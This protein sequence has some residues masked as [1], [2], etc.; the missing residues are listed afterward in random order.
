MAICTNCGYILNNEDM[1]KHVC[2]AADIPVAG[3]AKK[4]T[5]TS[6]AVEAI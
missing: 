4:P 6:V 5:T 3:T 2:K 1:G